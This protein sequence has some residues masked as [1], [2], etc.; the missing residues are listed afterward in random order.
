V[1]ALRSNEEHAR[2]VGEI[3]EL[4][5]RVETGRVND[6]SCLKE[7][8]R[9]ARS[10]AEKRRIM[11]EENRQLYL[12][13]MTWGEFQSLSRRQQ[14]HECQKFTQPVMTY[15][16]CHK[17]CRLSSCRRARACKGFIS[18]AQYQEGGYHEAFPPCLGK[19]APLHQEALAAMATACGRRPAADDTPKY[20]GHP[21]DRGET[22]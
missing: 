2:C 9:M 1:W 19:G 17:T 12:P 4:D 7:K 10:E 20:A 22:E 15:L 3:S 21:S 13:W 16:G 11:E 8:A 14:A 18:E 5:M 6:G